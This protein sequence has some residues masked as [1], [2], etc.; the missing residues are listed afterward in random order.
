[1]AAAS[2]RVTAVVVSFNRRELLSRGIDALRAQTRPPDRIIVVDNGSIDGTRDDLRARATNGEIV[3][4]E[5]SQNLGGA[6]GFE[7][8]IAWALEL[9]CD[10]AWLMDDDAIPEQDCLERLLDAASHLEAPS[11]LA[12]LVT[13]EAGAPGERNHPEIDTDVSAQ[14]EIAPL[15]CVAVKASTFVGPLLSATAMRQTHLPLGDFFIWHDDMEYTARLSTFG[16]AALVPSAR[17]AHLV[18]NRGPLHYNGARN[19]YNV[20]N[21]LWWLREVRRN[22]SFNRNRILLSLLRSLR[23][24]LRGAPNKLSYL[25]V[26]AK[27]TAEGLTKSPRHRTADDVVA[28]SRASDAFVGLPT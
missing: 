13:D 18:Q 14:C 28:T 1:M 27:A 23:Q 2:E 26:V 4:I 6:G 5:A 19:R 24:Q 3:L 15:G 9:G 12:P 25:W 8:G 10:W 7:R 11:F 21:Y 22:R 20:R 17:I 16:R